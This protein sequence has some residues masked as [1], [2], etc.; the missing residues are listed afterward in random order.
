VLRFEGEL[1]EHMHQNHEEVMSTIRDSQDFA[2]ETRD[3]V[4]AAIEQFK[5][6]FVA[7]T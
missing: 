6:G 1:L 3:Q 2:D 4:H 7:S 5:S